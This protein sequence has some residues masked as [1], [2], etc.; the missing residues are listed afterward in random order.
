MS[1][2]GGPLMVAAM[3]LRGK[4]INAAGFGGKVRRRG[5]QASTNNDEGLPIGAKVM[6]AWIDRHIKIRVCVSGAKPVAI[7][8]E[9]SG[10][11]WARGEIGVV[12]E[13]IDE[14]FSMIRLGERVLSIVGFNVELCVNGAATW[15]GCGNSGRTLREASCAEKKEQNRKKSFHVLAPKTA[16][17]D[18]AANARRRY[19]RILAWH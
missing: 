9:A 16:T 19:G 11:S 7:K 4:E 8:A 17:N 1:H 18:L 2:S 10:R 13:E 12:L 14:S 15:S 3:I 6:L 5:S